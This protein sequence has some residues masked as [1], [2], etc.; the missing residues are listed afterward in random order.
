M[1]IINVGLGRTGTLSTCTAYEQL[2]FKSHHM[3]S[4]MVDPQNRSSD[5]VIDFWIKCF[6]LK[7]AGQ[8]KELLGQLKQEMAYFSA[9]CDHPSA[10]FYEELAELYPEAIFMLNVRDSPEAWAK[11]VINSIANYVDLQFHPIYGNF[12]YFIGGSKNFAD[13]AK[14]LFK[15]PTNNHKF[16][17]DWK[18]VEFLKRHY[19]DRNQKVREFFRRPENQHLNFFE[20]NVKSGWE[21]IC[22][23]L[24]VPMPD[25][26]F[27]RVND[28]AE[29]Q[30]RYKMTKILCWVIVSIFV[31]AGLAFMMNCLK[32]GLILS[33]FPFFW[34]LLTIHVLIPMSLKNQ[35]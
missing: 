25:Q 32:T 6:E 4:V 23:A 33:V 34:R 20:F 26:P 15:T 17:E 2:G 29:Q 16:P 3:K 31:L 10:N 14:F 27:P 1:K 35:K 5:E 18:N 7:E 9:S 28:T 22:S 13:M 24:G 21:P 11:S 30:A 8:K 12:M 19:I